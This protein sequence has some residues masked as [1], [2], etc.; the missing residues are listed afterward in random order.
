MFEM[1][2]D[3]V[4]VTDVAGYTVR[5]FGQHLLDITAFDT[6]QHRIQAGALHFADASAPTDLVIEKGIDD[7]P[8]FPVRSFVHRGQLV[9]GRK[10]VLQ[11]R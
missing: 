2:A 6:V 7:S 5:R 11:I 1:F 10:G 3:C 8:A 4:S 9:G